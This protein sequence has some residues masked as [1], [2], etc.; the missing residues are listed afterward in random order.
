MIELLQLIGLCALIAFA[1]KYFFLNSPPPK[2]EAAQEPPPPP[3]EPNRE[4]ILEARY[5]P[6]SNSIQ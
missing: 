5:A 6:P 3:S 2:T 4:I 1:F